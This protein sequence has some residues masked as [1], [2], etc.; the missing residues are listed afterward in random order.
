MA[1]TLFAT[2]DVGSHET[3]LRIYEISK[4]YGVHEIEYVHHTAKLG[5]ETYS[6]NHISYPTI[7]KLCT[8]LNGFSE[9]MKEYAITDYMI[10]ATSALR[11]ADNNLIVLDRVKQRTG[12]LIKILSNSEQR[13]LCYKALGL[14]ENLFHNLIKQ[15][16]LIVDVGGGS[17]QLTL[18]DHNSL[19]LTQN[20]ML[21]S[22]RIHEILQDM[23]EETDN[24]KNLVYEYIYHDIHTFVDVYLKGHDVKNII[25]IGNQLNSFIQYI[26][27]HHFGSFDKGTNIENNKAS[28]GKTE[29]HEFYEAITS[30]KPQELAKE[31]NITLDKA[32]L[33]LPIVMIYR[34]IFDETNADNIWLSGI[35]ICDGMAA[36]FAERKEKIIPAFSFTEGIINAARNI[37]KRYQCYNKHNIIVEHFCLTLFDALKKQNNLNKNDRLLLQLAAILHN[38]GSFININDVGENSYKIIMSTEIIGISHKE[39]VSVAYIIRYLK[40]DFPRY[41]KISDVFEQAEFIKLT[42]L[43]AILRLANSMDRSHRQKFHDI[44]VEINKKKMIVTGQTLY[45]ITLEQ[46]MFREY[47]DAFEEVYGIKPVLKQKKRF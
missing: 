39:R 27:M 2:I 33:L 24:Y 17:I 38:C 14:K 23:E 37:A 10:T 16:T 3:A 31:L 26:G 21:G 29:Y 20:I 18:F 42:K 9:K 41:A 1:V 5:L 19:V 4:K 15:G 45:D 22:L 44:D 43:N 7:D 12:F 47:S 46:G 30:Q 6:T 34:T 35:S 32:E 40:E 13:Y 8:I 25:A 28:I 36:D 11:E